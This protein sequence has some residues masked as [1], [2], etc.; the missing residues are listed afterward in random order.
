VRDG[1]SRKKS[2]ARTAFSSLAMQQPGR[3]E[4]LEDIGSIS[5]AGWCSGP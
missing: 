2:E 1:L 5:D 3:F 4:M